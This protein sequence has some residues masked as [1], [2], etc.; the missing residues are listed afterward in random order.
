MSA[1]K[2][3]SIFKDG[4][5]ITETVIDREAMIGRADDCVIRLDDRAI[6]R[7][8]LSVKPSGD[9]VQVERRSEFAPLSVNGVEVTRAIVKEGD[10]V[11]IGPYL[12][13][14]KD[15]VEESEPQA[16]Q[17]PQPLPVE[18]T[19][20]KAAA[21]A[22]VES[23]VE[24]PDLGAP[25][26]SETPSANPVES[27]PPAELEA[28]PPAELSAS[29]EGSS[30]NGA[31]LLD[32]GIHN[33]PPAEAN[34]Q[35]APETPTFEDPAVADEDARTRI[36]A[37]N[38]VQARLV[39][40]AGAA[41][42]E[43]FEMDRDEVSIGR[44]KNCDIVLNDKRSSRKHA[45]I[46]RDGLRFVIRDLESANGVFVND[47]KIGEHELSSEDRIR[48]GDVEFVFQAQSAD[49]AAKEAAGFESIP[50]DPMAPDSG[51]VE[52]GGIV[53]ESSPPGAA[54]LVAQDP[55]ASA[56]AMPLDLNAGVVPPAGGAPTDFAGVPGMGVPANDP[57]KKQSI[58][59]YIKNYNKL[60]LSRKILIIAFLWLAVDNGMEF[61]KPEPPKKEA[62]KKGTVAPSGASVVKTF[63]QLS[64]AD[65]KFVENQHRLAFEYYRQQDFDRALYEAMEIYKVLPPPSYKDTDEIV[66][67][68][69][70]GKRLL[71]QIKE[72]ERRK[73]EEAKIKAKVEE[74]VQ[75][76]REKMEAK[77]YPA[78]RDL[79]GEVMALDPENA[80]V[81]AWKKEIEDFEEAQRLAE[82]ERQVQAEINRRAEDAL[83][84]A[85]ALRKKGQ[86]HSAIE[87]YRQI[88]DIGSNDPKIA[89]AATQGASACKAYIRSRREPLLQEAQTL[90][91]SGE[92]AQAFKL[93]QRATRIDPPHPAGYAGM[94]RVR[95][96]LHERAKLI[97]AEGVLAES[98]SDFANAERKFKEVLKVAPSDDIYFERSQKKISNYNRM[99]IP[100]GL[101]GGTEEAN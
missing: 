88:P 74:L 81:A 25:S 76:I 62:P 38:R 33:D 21:E 89:R 65:K 49:Y 86:C 75:Q 48:I 47:A 45:V 58:V 4:E 26:A 71:E 2:L 22:S 72:E 69:R 8:H 11:A 14:V 36:V 70:D 54:P 79:F 18:I 92:F 6:S 31:L 91:H 68:S 37:T 12:L 24:L 77:D 60:P 94:K 27:A 64:P 97:Y 84:E 35:Q 15:T 100:A 44:G 42:V 5:T 30:E 101:G 51:P 7:Q 66:R 78:A 40:P 20:V 82:Q 19:N 95:G 98:F 56:A 83:S 55:A 52:A 63:E 61:F 85:N 10:V 46:R 80:Q 17:A 43:T 57:K 96:I 90:E 1:A 28:S 32:G 53:F 39:F 13:R 16:L 93:Y 59:D 87:V 9:G 99:R 34:A 67:L 3:L 41:N 50:D 73:E 29:V 23:Q